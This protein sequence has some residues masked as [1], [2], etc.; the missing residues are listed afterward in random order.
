MQ[1]FGAALLADAQLFYE[2]RLT[3]VQLR[4]DD[5]EPQLVEFAERARALA[6]ARAWPADSGVEPLLERIDRTRFLT[7]G[8]ATFEELSARVDA[9][10]APPSDAELRELAGLTDACER[11]AGEGHALVAELVAYDELMRGYAQLLREFVRQQGELARAVRENSH[12]PPSVKL[13][14]ELI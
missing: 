10:A 11:I 9:A 4:F 5:L 7:P 12:R 1:T 14:N 13:L 2:Y 3:L 6:G 8:R